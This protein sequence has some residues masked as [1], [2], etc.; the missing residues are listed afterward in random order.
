MTANSVTTENRR[1]QRDAVLLGTIR[2][3]GIDVTRSVPCIR[4]AQCQERGEVD[5]DLVGDANI[6]EAM[7]NYELHFVLCVLAFLA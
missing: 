5:R 6:V 1:T 3:C 2:V 4:C 7:L